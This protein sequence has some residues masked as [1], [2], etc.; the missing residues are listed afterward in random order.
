MKNLKLAFFVAIFT[1]TAA[2]AY[3]QQKLRGRVIEILDGKTVV[4]QLNTNHKI[5]A[6][7]Q[8]IEVP[9]PQQPLHQ[10]VKEHLQKLVLGQ[11]AEFQPLRLFNSMSVGR[12]VVNGV[13]I[14]QQMIRD[15]AA[16]YA[17]PEKSSQLPAES[18][19]Y[20]R[21]EAQAKTEKRGVW[22][23]ENMKP[24]WE[25][26]ADLLRSSERGQETVTTETAASTTLADELQN[27]RPKTRPAMTN[28]FGSSVLGDLGNIGF[29]KTEN[30]S[31]IYTETIP[32]TDLSYVSTGSGFF[33]IANAKSRIEVESRAACFYHK[34]SASGKFFLIGFR[35]G[36]DEWRDLP[37]TDLTLAVGKQKIFSA[38][39][40]K[41]VKDFVTARYRVI[42]YEVSREVLEKAAK[43]ENLTIKI[44]G[45][46]GKISDDYRA[47]IE[48]MLY[49]TG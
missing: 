1:L 20:Q 5:T 41:F 26:R 11:E 49:V 39:S 2:S 8:F 13:D 43:T 25:F 22:G 46:S 18:E 12:L 7:L 23:I 37:M 21:T 36:A 45:F 35:A 34:N 44:G 19:T 40:S 32:N 3:S 14:S 6:G 33:K 47:F 17:V 30:N 24:A 27:R 31:E 48:K 10:I 28:D 29:G 4:I 9:E 38:K 42:F 16:W 15:G